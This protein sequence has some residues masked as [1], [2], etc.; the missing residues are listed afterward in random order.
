MLKNKTPYYA[1]IFSN[2]RITTDDVFYQ[3]LSKSLRASAK[4]QPGYLGLESYSSPDG[5]GT[6]ISYWEDL[7]SI[8]AWR[9]N[10]EHVVAQHYGRDT[11][12]ANYTVRVCEVQREY[13]FSKEENTT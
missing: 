7:K 11:A 2:Q 12:Y 10:A 4:S 1:V 3:N 5:T 9:K 6:T 8:A 13:Q